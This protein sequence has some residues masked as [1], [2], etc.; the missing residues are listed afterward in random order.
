M[1][2][3]LTALQFQKKILVWFNTHGR[4]NLPW[5]QAISPY[6]VWVS[7]IMLQQT[8]VKTVIPYY[9][10]FMQRF[11]TISKLA[12]ANLDEVLHYWTG[13]GYYARARNLYKAATI[14]MHDF[15]GSFPKKFTEIITLPGI[16]RSTAGAICALALKQHYAILDGNVKRVL[17]RFAKIQ[18]WPGKT[19]VADKLWQLAEHYTPQKHIAEYTQAMMDLGATLCTR[20]NPKCTD[21]P[22]TENCLAHQ[23][24]CEHQYPTK[25]SKK[26]L[27]I[28]NTIMMLIKNTTAEWLL[29]KRPSTGIWGG[30]WLFPQCETVKDIKHWCWQHDIIIKRQVS[31]SS[32][33]HTFSH[34]HLEITPILI[35]TNTMI[36]KI[37]DAQ[38]FIWYNHKQQ[39]GLAAP[40][41]KL[42]MQFAR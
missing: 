8:Q 32:F 27:P 14:I 26:Q 34:Y 36:N 16:G 23:T 39:I 41:K 29:E 3:K 13:L 11:P 21:C 2:K 9:Q 24:H 31:L 42:L 28:K 40:V 22:L 20:S 5:Q 38:Q 4:K 15:N 30:L 25:K 33:R 7:E 6:R 17:A 10:Q 19:S 35:E 18:G 37:M 12:I 1:A